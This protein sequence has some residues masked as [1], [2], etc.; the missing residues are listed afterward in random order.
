MVKKEDATVFIRQ[1]SFAG[2]AFYQLPCERSVKGHV[3]LIH[4]IWRRGW[5]TNPRV[6][7]IEPVL[8]RLSETLGLFGLPRTIVTDNATPFTSARFRRYCEYDR[9]LSGATDALLERAYEARLV[10]CT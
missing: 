2:P 9:C 7:I 5:D 6:Q 8:R 3:V 1:S 4:N 10:V